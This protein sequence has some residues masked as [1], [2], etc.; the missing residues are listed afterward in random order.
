MMAVCLWFFGGERSGIKKSGFR[1]ASE[2][3]KNS[4]PVFSQVMS[5]L[6]P[7]TFAR[8]AALFPLRRKPR[9]LS[10]Y[11]HFLALCFA[12]FTYRESLRDPAASLERAPHAVSVPSGF[13]RTP[14]PAPIW[15]TPTNDAPGVLIAAVA[16]QVLHALG[17]PVI[18][19]ASL[20]PVDLPA[21]AF[22]PDALCSCIE[23]ASL[24][25][26]GGGKRH[27]TAIC[28]HLLL[29]QACNLHDRWATAAPQLVARGCGSSTTRPW[30]RAAFHVMDRGCLDFPPY[31]AAGPT[32]RF[33]RGPRQTPFRSFS[34][35]RSNLGGQNASACVA[36]KPSARPTAYRHRSLSAN[37]CR[38]R[39]WDDTKPKSSLLTNHFEVLYPQPDGVVSLTLADRTV[40][41]MDHV[42]NI[43]ACADFWGRLPNAV[44]CQV[45]SRLFVSDLSLGGHSP[46]RKAT[47][48]KAW[49]E[50][51]QNLEPSTH[52]E[53]V[54]SQSCLQKTPPKSKPMKTRSHL[55][56]TL[57]SWTA[58]SHTRSNRVKPLFDL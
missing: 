12:Q 30:S 13:S 42:N 54:L 52:L 56:S 49:Y 57:Y 4:S 8:C 16:H 39:W 51:L 26:A 33:F 41:Q 24:P 47:R 43:C 27:A 22:A 45:C 17:A 18:S 9:G 1:I 44:Q 14:L 3:P 37:P 23:C 46:A 34:V 50:I 19:T 11:D 28:S 21:A 5:T 10:V 2:M 6:H 40:L 36:T 32:R 25:R 53:Q 31:C 55:I 15:L 38:V 58:V 29:A 7:Q 48:T 20:A 35:Q